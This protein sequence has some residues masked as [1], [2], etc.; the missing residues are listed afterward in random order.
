MMFRTCFYLFFLV[1]AT[2]SSAA[3]RPNI[4]VILTDDMGFSDL[5]CF[6]GEIET[7]HL[8]HLA[9][10]PLRSPLPK[11]KFLAVSLCVVTK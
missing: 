9:A 10:K 7:P 2:M 5:G 6:G 4:L 1:V 11:S 8:D 3:K